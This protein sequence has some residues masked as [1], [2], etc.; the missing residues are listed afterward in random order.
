MADFSR[1]AGPIATMVLADLGADVVKVE[2]PG[3]G[4]ETRTWGPPGG[5]RRR[6]NQHLL[7]EREP[8]Q[9]QHRPGPTGP[10]RP[11]VARRIALGA[12][13]VVDN[14]RVGT[15]AQFGL[16]R[17]SLAVEHPS[18]ITCSV[19]ASAVGGGGRLAG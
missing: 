11:G 3:V 19:T 1:L 10:Q 2:Q 4:D 13:V 6:R 8:Q 18:V 9:A 5:G 16:D 14:F 12:D 15:M 17:D 7:P